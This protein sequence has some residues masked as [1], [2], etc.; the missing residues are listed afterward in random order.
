VAADAVE[1]ITDAV[2]LSSFSYSAAVVTEMAL[3]L[4]VLHAV[5]ADVDL[6][7]GSS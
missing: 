3:A 1:M 2:G 4:E 7:S 6:S 5:M